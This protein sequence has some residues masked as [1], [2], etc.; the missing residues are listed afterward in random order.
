M[1]REAVDCFIAANDWGRARRLAKEIDPTMAL[2]SHV[3]KQ[4][5]NQLKVEGRADQLADIGKKKLRLRNFS[6]HITFLL[7]KS[8]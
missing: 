4:Q 3:D 6:V 7:Q 1:P 2:L 8:K 5:K